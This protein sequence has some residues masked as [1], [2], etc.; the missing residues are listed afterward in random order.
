MNNKVCKNCCI[1]KNINEFKNTGKLCRICFNEYMKNRR[2]GMKILINK[3]KKTCKNCHI[4]KDINE[5]KNTGKLC[6]ICF[7]L[8]MKNRRPKKIK[9]FKID[10][11]KTCNKCHIEKDINEY[12][13]SN[14]SIDNHT[15]I[16][17]KCS[18]EI[19]K[20]SRKA[21]AGYI[22]IIINPAWTDYIKLGRTQDITLRLS[23]YQTNTPHRD[24]EM[25]YNCYTSDLAYIE[26]YFNM[27]IIGKYEWFKIDKD[28]AVTLINSLI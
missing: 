28:E 16:C 24:Y 10:K 21:I 25:Y 9:D 8:Y 5:F 4:E 26:S 14:K 27:N 18:S 23:Q 12:H 6:R 1:E 3:D 20:D 15:A 22:Y 2:T 13:I 11:L 7:N 17:K 19:G